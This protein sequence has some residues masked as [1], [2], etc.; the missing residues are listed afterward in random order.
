MKQISN[1][2]SPVSCLLEAIVRQLL[3]PGPPSELASCCVPASFRCTARPLMYKNLKLAI[4]LVLWQFLL[5]M[6]AM[7]MPHLRGRYQPC[8]QLLHEETPLAWLPQSWQILHIDLQSKR[9]RYGRVMGRLQPG[10][11]LVLPALAGPPHHGLLQGSHVV[12]PRGR[13]GVA[14]AGRARA[15]GVQQA[16]IAEPCRRSSGFSMPSAAADTCASC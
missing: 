7:Q 16:A 12:Q 13:P 2:C 14:H 3:S 11:L 10:R 5:A 15:P 1:P 8:S 6:L 4:S 9:G